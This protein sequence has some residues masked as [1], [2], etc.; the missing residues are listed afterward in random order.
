MGG[1]A[2]GFVLGKRELSEF[3]GG[4]SELKGL[5]RFFADV[6]VNNA[7]VCLLAELGDLTDVGILAFN[8]LGEEFAQLIQ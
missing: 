4:E 1:A 7:V 5:A 2:A 3:G 8:G 6:A